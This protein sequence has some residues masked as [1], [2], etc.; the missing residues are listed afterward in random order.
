MVLSDQ[1]VKHDGQAKEYKQKQKIRILDFEKGFTLTAIIA[2]TIPQ[3]IIGAT[4]AFP[5][6]HRNF[7][8]HIDNKMHC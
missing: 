5:G 2:V 4:S 8:V 1:D 3:S 7:L 6:L